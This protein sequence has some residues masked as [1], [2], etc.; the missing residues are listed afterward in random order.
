MNRKKIKCNNCGS[1]NHTYKN[2]KNPVS[3]YGVILFKYI[4]EEP[5]ILMINRKD[6]LCYIDLLRG[7]YNLNDISYIQLLINKC[8][9]PEKDKIIKKDF[10]TLWKE[11]WLLDDIKDTKFNNDY[12]KGK[13][14]FDTLT[15]GIHDCK[16][17]KNIN[18]QSLIENSTTSYKTPEWEFPKGRRNNN[19]TNKDCAIR[20]CQEETNYTIEDY[21]LFINMM[22]LSENY[23]GENRVKYRHIYYIA[24]IISDRDALLDK[25]NH[26][27]SLEI[28]D[29]RWLNYEQSLGLIRNYHKTREDVIHKM[30]S[31]LKNIDDYILI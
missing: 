6:S 25:N 1:T 17:D 29:I 11:L 20:E 8:S 2:C 31:F 28:S 23:T 18:F 3:S 21:D 24:K 27:Q 9:I 16:T 10:D 5:H 12:K 26:N 22:P 13:H 4:D 15:E 7:K 19:E 30:F 14:K